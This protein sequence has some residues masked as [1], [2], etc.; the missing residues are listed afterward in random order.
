[1]GY[2]NRRDIEV[3]SFFM[4]DRLT[5]TAAD[6]IKQRG[7]EAIAM[8]R[9]YKPSVVFLT[10]DDAMREVAVAYNQQYA[11]EKLPFIFSGVNVDPTIYSDIKSLAKPVAPMTGALERIPFA[12]AFTTIKGLYP[13]AKKIVL[14]ADDGPSSH[15]VIDAYNAEFWGKPGSLG[16]DVVELRTVKTFKEFQGLIADYQARADAIGLLNF[17]R[18]TDEK[19]AFVTG[20]DVMRWLAQNDKL[21]AVAL[22]AAWA[23]NGAPMSVGNSG[24][25][26]GRYVG[27]IGGQVLKGK[28]AGTI[29]IVDPHTVE[30]QVNLEAATLQGV[31]FPPSVLANAA[32]VYQKIGGVGE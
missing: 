20:E 3:K 8:I 6:K 15:T 27:V 5:N 23:Q 11:S 31:T 7:V 16:L 21:P 18:F 4:D 28:D 1:M 25:N 13:N 12:D 17:H 2:V 14:L 22:V 24:V 26:M 30:T 29:A 32:K 9:S 10:D 19:G